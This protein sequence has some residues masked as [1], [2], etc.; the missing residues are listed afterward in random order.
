MQILTEKIE[1]HLF[2]SKSN[3]FISKGLCHLHFFPGKFI[4]KVRVLLLDLFCCFSNG[5]KTDKK[6]HF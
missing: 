3:Y 4:H 5:C 1:I 2:K 6:L